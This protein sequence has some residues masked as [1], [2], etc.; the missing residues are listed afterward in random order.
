MAVEAAAAAAQ[1]LGLS[2]RALLCNSGQPPLKILLHAFSFVRARDNIGCLP[3]FPG[4]TEAQLCPLVLPGCG[5]R[6]L[7]WVPWPQ[8]AGVGN[9]EAR[10]GARMLRVSPGRRERGVGVLALCVGKMDQAL[11]FSEGQELVCF[12]CAG[13]AQRSL[14]QTRAGNA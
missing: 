3:S 13:D 7:S 11:L 14:G 8:Q 10:R 9:A 5:G 4:A 2:G 1:R 12:E 6:G